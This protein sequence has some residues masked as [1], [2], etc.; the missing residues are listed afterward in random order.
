MTRGAVTGSSFDPTETQAMNT[1]PAPNDEKEAFSITD[2]RSAV[3]Y[4]RKIRQIGEE[5][6]AIKA[7][8]AQRL[9]E[10][11]VDQ[12]RL[13]HLYSDQLRA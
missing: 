2:E 3:W 6:E 10:L 9:H 5:R 8:T 11:D 4:L 7:A 12:K 1:N 13:E